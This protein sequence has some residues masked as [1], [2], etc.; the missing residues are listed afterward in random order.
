MAVLLI[1]NIKQLIGTWENPSLLQGKNLS[2]LPLIDDAFI[3]VEDGIIVDWRHVQAG[4]KSTAF[5]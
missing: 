1:T 5:A 4:I 3:L 2:K